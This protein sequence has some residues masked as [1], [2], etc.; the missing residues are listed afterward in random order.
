MLA[1]PLDW[2]LVPEVGERNPSQMGWQ[3]R[4][5]RDSIHLHDRSVT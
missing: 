5:G 1:S 4:L 3:R 2:I